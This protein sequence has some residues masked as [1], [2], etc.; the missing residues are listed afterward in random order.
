M[1]IGYILC[2]FATRFCYRTPLSFGYNHADSGHYIG[3]NYVLVCT[4]LERSSPDIRP[5]NALDSVCQGGLK[6]I[7]HTYTGCPRRNG[8]NFGGVFLMLKYTDIT[9]NTFVQS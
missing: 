9:Q 2:A 4:H 1:K 3:H 7:H 8:Q 5:Q 6:H